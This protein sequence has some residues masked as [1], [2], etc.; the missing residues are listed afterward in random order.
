MSGLLG[1]IHSSHCYYR[2]Y[3]VSQH[4]AD[5]CFVDN[6]SWKF[7]ISNWAAGQLQKRRKMSQMC[8]QKIACKVPGRDTL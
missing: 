1:T 6:K 8:Q 7:R 5:L 4:L 3:R 2:V